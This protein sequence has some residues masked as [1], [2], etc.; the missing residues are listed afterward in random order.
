[1]LDDL[2]DALSRFHENR[3]IFEI[4]GI[5]SD[6]FALPRQHS[7]THYLSMIR[8]FG[9]PNGLCSS[10]TESKHRVAVKKPWRRS[11]RYKAL[12]QMLLINQ[13]L[14]KLAAARV[15]FASRGMLDGTCLSDALKNLGTYFL[16]LSF[17]N[18]LSENL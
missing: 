17:I 8:S 11:R 10:I 3:T 6:G 2:Q 14:D 9:A 15:D 12:G 7:M 5:R 1:M 13:R 16:H 18:C 4:A